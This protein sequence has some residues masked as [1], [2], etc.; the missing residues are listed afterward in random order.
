MC[1]A[2]RI[3]LLQVDISLF[4]SLILFVDTLRSSFL[5]AEEVVESHRHAFMKDGTWNVKIQHLS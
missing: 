3:F 1:M 4:Q 2:F 5:S